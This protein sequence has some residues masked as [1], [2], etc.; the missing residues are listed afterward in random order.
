MAPISAVLTAPAAAQFIST[1]I[2]ADKEQRDPHGAP[3]CGNSITVT[4]IHRQ[5]AWH[6]LVC[7]ERDLNCP[8]VVMWL[9]GSENM[10]EKL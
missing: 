3:S 1:S 4:L 9:S 10:V 2:S 5:Q 8:E 6:C 7:S